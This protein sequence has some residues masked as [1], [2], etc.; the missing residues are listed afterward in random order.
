MAAANKRVSNLLDKAENI[1]LIGAVDT[2]LFEEAAEK[3][4]FDE[5]ETKEVNV[6]PLFSCNK[7]T[8]GL[9]ELCLLKD[10]VDRFFDDVLVMCEDKAVQNNRLALLQ[11]LRSVFL[12]VADISYLHT[13]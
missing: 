3:H 2:A 6:A 11:R 7:Y 1:S 12:Q 13:S 5:L 10:A 8:E 4:L 9:D